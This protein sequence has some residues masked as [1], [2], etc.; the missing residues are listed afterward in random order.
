MTSLFM[1]SR[2]YAPHLSLVLGG[3]CIS[4]NSRFR[5]EN[6]SSKK[7]RK[8][9][10][11]R[12][13]NAIKRTKESYV[14]S[15]TAHGLSKILTGRKAERIF[16]LFSVLAVLSI[17]TYLC[18]NYFQRYFKYEVQTNR[19]AEKMLEMPL[20]AIML[21]QDIFCFNS[22]K[23]I[24][25]YKTGKYV[26]SSKPCL[27]IELSLDTTESNVTK[28][29][30]DKCLIVNRMTQ[31]HVTVPVHMSITS[32]HSYPDVLIAIG[33]PDMYSGLTTFLFNDLLLPRLCSATI[34]I[35]RTSY[36]QLS[37]SNCTTSMDREHF[38]SDIYSKEVCI[39]SCYLR[40]ML[41]SCGTVIDNWTN[42]TKLVKV[43]SNEKEQL[44]NHTQTVAC[45][46][47][48]VEQM[49]HHRVPNECHCPKSCN[50]VKYDVQ[51][52]QPRWYPCSYPIKCP[53]DVNNV[54]DDCA[55]IK[56]TFKYQS[57]KFKSVEEI[58]AYSLSNLAADTGSIVGAMTGIS[59]LSI[60][61]VLVF[62]FIC[63]VGKFV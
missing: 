36:K 29:L 35:E 24:M 21:C 41:Q 46:L 3:N 11:L 38:F 50:E 16:W 57:N 15:F 14:G 5:I 43:S 45:I 28:H 10:M 34:S 9:N 40:K 30:G 23:I 59:L 17:A 63:L 44:K 42:Y 22:K 53:G 27:P 20:P 47:N 2:K 60:A 55:R 19:K 62:I 12:C 26:L 56:L 4:N 54:S 1:Q 7:K 51:I 13:Q 58:P 8:N 52:A 48:L 18:S 32:R 6:T 31:K 49:R 25:D 33:D 39:Q 61:E 37:S